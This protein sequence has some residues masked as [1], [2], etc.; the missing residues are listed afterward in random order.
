[1]AT[2]KLPAATTEHPIIVL[3]RGVKYL[4][5]DVSYRKLEA[6]VRGAALAREALG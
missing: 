5:R 2:R 4:T 6:M 3:D 1:M